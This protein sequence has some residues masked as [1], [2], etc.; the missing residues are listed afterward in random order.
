MIM[1][2]DVDLVQRVK[3]GDRKAFAMLVERHEKPIFNLAVR[4]VRDHDDAADI[5]QNTFV[6]AYRKLGSFNPDYKFFSWLY[7]IAANEALNHLRRHKRT[8]E[9]V[10]DPPSNRPLPDDDCDRHETRDQ[11]A[12][13]LA[14]MTLDQR[15]VIILKHLLFLSYRDIAATLEITEKTV[16]SRLYSARQVL[17]EQL[18]QQGYRR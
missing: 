6:K 7:R 2:D 10:S 12:Q 15:I 3:L 18:V 9:L 14:A 5:T 4:M 1:I 13:A 8:Q 16:K 11:I 17:K